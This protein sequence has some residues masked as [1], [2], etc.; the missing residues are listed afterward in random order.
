MLTAEDEIVA[1]MD[2]QCGMQRDDLTAE[3]RRRAALVAFT[4]AG[5]P[6]CVGAAALAGAR[7][8]IA[9]R[10]ARDLAMEQWLVGEVHLRG[11]RENAAALAAGNTRLTSDPARGRSVI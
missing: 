11:V 4:G 2:A 3:E 5:L 8:A 6:H 9:M 10:Q 1:V 7:R